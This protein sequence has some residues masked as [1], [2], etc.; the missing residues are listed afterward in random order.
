VFKEHLAGKLFQESIHGQCEF[1][2][3]QQRFSLT[4]ALDMGM[5]NLCVPVTVDGSVNN[6]KATS[7]HNFSA[8]TP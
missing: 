5:C 4:R 8:Q 3:P 2:L 7:A 6:Y 1:M